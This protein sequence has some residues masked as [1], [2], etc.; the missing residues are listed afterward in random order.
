MEEYDEPGGAGAPEENSGN[1]ILNL[2]DTDDSIPKYEALAA[3]IYNTVVESCERELSSAG[4]DM[5]TWQFKVI[6]P[7]NPKE[8]GRLFFYHTV[9][10]K[11]AGLGRLKR[12]VIRVLPD[13]DIANLD[14]DKF[15]TEGVAIGAPARVKVK[16]ERYQNER[17]NRVTDVL[18]A[19]DAAFMDEVT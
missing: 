5:I 15:V 14:V 19:D 13:V 1:L 9:L 4:N 2:T 7:E 6:N 8:D 16:I 12:L 10:N 11:E 18:A 3:G 17:R